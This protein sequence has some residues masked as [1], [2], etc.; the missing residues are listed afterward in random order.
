MAACTGGHADAAALLLSHGADV[1]AAD[2]NGCT[3]A[4]W[5]V[6]HD[7]DAALLRT[8]LRAG[9]RIDVQDS[10]GRTPLHLAARHGR[11]T[12][13]RMMLD[14]RGIAGQ[15]EGGA[16][17]VAAAAGAGHVDAA[18]LLVR[19]G[20]ALPDVARGS[21]LAA[22]LAAEV[23][24]VPEARRGLQQLVVGAAGE[25]ARLERARA[26][27]AQPGHP[28]GGAATAAAQDGA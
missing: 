21:P 11:M 27:A 15:P 8:L 23:R 18:M 17:A 7:N 25:M 3:C 22:A 1:N 9:A 19:A 14:A 26:A 24:A 20:A 13:L 12:L 10:D 5:A 4:H 28:E 2:D 16:R 6:I